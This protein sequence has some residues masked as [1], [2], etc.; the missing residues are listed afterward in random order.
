MNYARLASDIAIADFHN[1]LIKQVVLGAYGL[2][3][4]LS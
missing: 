4:T 1:F 3:V 2:F